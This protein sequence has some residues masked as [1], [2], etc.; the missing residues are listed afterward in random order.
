MRC[1]SCVWNS[2]IPSVVCVDV[3]AI[4]REWGRNVSDNLYTVPWPC[5]YS[6]HGVKHTVSV[7]LF[8]VRHLVNVLTQVGGIEGGL[9]V[10][11]GGEVPQGF[12]RYGGF[13]GEYIKSK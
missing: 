9:F 4:S 7:V 8:M 13:A 3:F 11:V 2:T 1:G 6:A 10:E 12:A 5:E